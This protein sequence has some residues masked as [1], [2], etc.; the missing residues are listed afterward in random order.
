MNEEIDNNL[1]I[2]ANSL[3]QFANGPAKH[4]GDIIA[5][6]FRTAGNEIS[7]ALE[8]AAKSGEFSMKKLVAAIIKELSQLALQ[9]YVF[10]PLE[11]GLKGT[12]SGVRQVLNSGIGGGVAQNLNTTSISA[13]V[14][15][16][17]NLPAGANLNEAR[18]S[19]SQISASLARLVNRGRGLL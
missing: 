11:D 17:I 2:A 8:H 3:T 16:T 4:A 18:K 10:A 13:P 9:K 19:A 5:Q 7:N 14:N 6:S 1:Q 12:F 15:F